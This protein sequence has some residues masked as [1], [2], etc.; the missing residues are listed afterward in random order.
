M[1]EFISMTTSA[2]DAVKQVLK[3]GTAGPSSVDSSKLSMNA[4]DELD[5]SKSMLAAV[6][7]GKK[8]VEVVKRPVP[9]ITDPVSGHSLFCYGLQLQNRG[10]A[11]PKKDV[12]SAG[13]LSVYTTVQSE[14]MALS[15]KNLWP[16]CRQLDG[17]YRRK[18]T[19][20]RDLRQ[21]LLLLW[22]HCLQSQ[23]PSQYC[24]V[25]W[26]RYLIVLCSLCQCITGLDLYLCSIPVLTSICVITA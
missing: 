24:W 14:G 26:S 10:A 22:W 21:K 8:S 17:H 4:V 9:K 25:S 16:C 2:V 6:W 15:A 13:V 12:W 20:C 5:D 7:Q 1:R 19:I 23:V 3:V 11:L 18:H